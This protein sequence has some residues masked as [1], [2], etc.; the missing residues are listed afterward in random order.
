MPV[1]ELNRA[2]SEMHAATLLAVAADLPIP[3]H[4]RV[5]GHVFPHESARETEEIVTVG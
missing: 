2:I 3:L 1:V 5:H 4:V